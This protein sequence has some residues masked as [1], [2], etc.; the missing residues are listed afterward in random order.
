LRALS[1]FTR[2]VLATLKHDHKGEKHMRGILF[3]LVLVGL[4]YFLVLKKE[5]VERFDLDEAENKVEQVEKEV[6]QALEDAQEKLDN[7]LNDQ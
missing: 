7:A 3:V 4:V 6:N 5:D 2:A 1:R